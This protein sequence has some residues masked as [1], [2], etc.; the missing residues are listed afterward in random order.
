MEETSRE[1]EREVGV[2]QVVE[3]TEEMTRRPIR[4]IEV[5]HGAPPPPC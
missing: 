4:R 5:A 3:G 2:D 1:A